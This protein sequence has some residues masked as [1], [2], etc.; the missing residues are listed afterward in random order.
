MDKQVVKLY[1]NEMQVHVLDFDFYGYM[2][3][4]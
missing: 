2:H 1:S 4:Q 3:I